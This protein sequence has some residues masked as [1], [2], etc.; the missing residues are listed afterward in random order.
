MGL[1]EAGA[2]ADAVAVG[3]WVAGIGARHEADLAARQLR[4]AERVRVGTELLDDLDAAGQAVLGELQ[5]L[6]AQ[7]DDDL[8]RAVDAGGQRELAAAEL[9]ASRRPPP[10]CTG[11]SRASR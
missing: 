5:R 2:Q 11:S 4:H 9:R 10:A 1:V 7:A 8:A 3:R 6:G